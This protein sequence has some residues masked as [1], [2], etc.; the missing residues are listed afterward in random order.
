[1]TIAVFAKSVSMITGCGAFFYECDFEDFL[2]DC[3]MAGKGIV[4]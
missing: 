4:K 2:A 3:V 1:M